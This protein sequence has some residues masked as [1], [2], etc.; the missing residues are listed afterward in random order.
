MYITTNRDRKQNSFRLH[1]ELTSIKTGRI[2]D[3]TVADGW[4]GAVMQQGRIHGQYQSRTVGQGRKCVFSHFP[5]RSPWTDEP[6]DRRTKPLIE[7]H[8]RN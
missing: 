7:L 6:T 3:R 1:C 4:A 5:T 2:H 8:V